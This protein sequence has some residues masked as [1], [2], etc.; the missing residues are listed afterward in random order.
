MLSETIFASPY[1]KYYSVAVENYNPVANV[2]LIPAFAECPHAQTAESHGL[3]CVLEQRG[4]AP[5]IDV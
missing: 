3:E 1:F 4:V 5:L 2:S